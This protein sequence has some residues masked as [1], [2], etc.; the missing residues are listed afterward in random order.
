MRRSE[1]RAVAL[2]IA[3]YQLR[4][5][6]LNLLEASAFDAHVALDEYAR[7][8]PDLIGSQ[9]YHTA[10]QSELNCFYREW[11]RWQKQQ[12]RLFGIG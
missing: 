1:Q 7:R 5:V 2:G 6:H 9:G 3:R 11:R 10:N 4:Q 8:F 12:R